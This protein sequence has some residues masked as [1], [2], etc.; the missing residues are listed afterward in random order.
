M[1]V[2]SDKGARQTAFSFHH[3]QQSA[4]YRLTTTGAIDVEPALAEID[5]HL[6]EV[7]MD[8]DLELLRGLRAYV[9]KYGPRGPVEGW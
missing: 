6:E 3:G 2:L 5:E 7:E 9:Q 1:R 4:L 8:I